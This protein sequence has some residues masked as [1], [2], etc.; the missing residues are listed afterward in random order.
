MARYLKSSARYGYLLLENRD[1]FIPDRYLAPPQRWQRRNFAKVFDAD[2]IRMIEL[3]YG[4]KNYDN[5]LSRF[6]LISQT[7]KDT[8]IV[9]MESEQ[10]T[11]PK[12]SNGTSLNDLECSLSQISRSWC[13][14]TQKRYKTE[15]YLR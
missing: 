13:Y 9:T 3:P 11:A 10:E 14:S 4:E 8:A 7:V 1:I 2:K 15:P 6:H 5:M 12:L